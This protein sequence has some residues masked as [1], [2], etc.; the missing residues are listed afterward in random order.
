MLFKDGEDEY[1]HL[2]ALVDF[3]LAM[4]QCLQDVNV[5]SFNNFQLR[6]GK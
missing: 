3:A 5:H 6:V 4:K 1:G 2:C